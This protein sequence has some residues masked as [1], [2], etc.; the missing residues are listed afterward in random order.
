MDHLDAIDDLRQG[1]WMRGDKNTV[2]AEYRKEAFA[3]FERLMA[4][5]KQTV[6]ERIFR[7]RVNPGQRVA[8]PSVVSMTAQGPSETAGQLNSGLDPAL[9][10][11]AKMDLANDPLVKRFN[12]PAPP[13]DKSSGSLAAALRRQQE[14]QQASTPASDKASS[15]AE[16]DI[17]AGVGRN[18]P[19]PCGS[20]KKF[21]KCHGRPQ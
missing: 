5:I 19:C 12:E 1:I 14:R 9:A 2:L 8:R 20:G 17:Y 21:K 6:I 11:L 15:R 13:S 7:V 18:D 16:K 3:L 4:M 10:E